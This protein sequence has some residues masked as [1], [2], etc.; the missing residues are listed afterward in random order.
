MQSFEISLVLQ[1][2]QLPVLTDRTVHTLHNQVN[3]KD[4]KLT[5]NKYIKLEDSY[6]VSNI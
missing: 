1:Q 2:L 5:K 6:L 3:C 4:K